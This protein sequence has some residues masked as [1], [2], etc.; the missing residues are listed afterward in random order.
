[1]PIDETAQP[2]L[3][4]ALDAMGPTRRAILVLLRG[5]AQA[6]AEEVAEHLDI[7]AS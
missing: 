2:H 4:P 1:M 7:T 5:R 3:S 6:G